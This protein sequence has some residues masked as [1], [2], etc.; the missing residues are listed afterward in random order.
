[1]VNHTVNQRRH[2]L[3]HA[4][5]TAFDVRT[6]LAANQRQAQRSDP[7]LNHFQIVDNR[8]ATNEITFG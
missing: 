3:T 8:C 4:A 5:L 7:G 1:M 2:R 6:A